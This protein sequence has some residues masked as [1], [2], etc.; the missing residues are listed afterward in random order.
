MTGTWGMTSGQKTTSPHLR[1]SSIGSHS[2]HGAPLNQHDAS[3]WHH[4][5]NHIIR[6]FAGRITVS[7]AILRSPMLDAGCFQTHYTLLN[8]CSLS[9]ALQPVLYSVLG[10]VPGVDVMARR[11]RGWVKCEDRLPYY[12][13]SSCSLPLALATTP[14]PQLQLHDSRVARTSRRGGAWAPGVSG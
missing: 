6:P 3:S 2:L 5:H 13:G 14:T 8:P 11:S 10:P 12:R 9:T 7:S 1:Q 4:A